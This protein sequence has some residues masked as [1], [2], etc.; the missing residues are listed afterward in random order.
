MLE[1]TKLLSSKRQRES[2][3]D[4]SDPLIVRNAFEADYDRIV[5]TAITG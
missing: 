2:N 5:G 4:V 1:W 3:S